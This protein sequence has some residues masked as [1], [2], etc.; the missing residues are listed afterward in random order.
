ME[1]AIAQRPFFSTLLSNM[2]S[3]MK[4]V[5]TL[6]LSVL[7][8]SAGIYEDLE[9]GDTKQEVT[10]KLMECERVE[11]TVPETMAWQGWVSMEHF[12]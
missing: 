9:Y 5:A 8:L 2:S 4:I 10:D 1:S 3:F 7:S 12:V 6:L 11:S